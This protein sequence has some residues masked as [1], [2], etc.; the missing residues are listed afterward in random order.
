MKQ[1][2]TDRWVGRVVVPPG[3]VNVDVYDTVVPGLV[4]RVGRRTKSWA[5]RIVRNGQ[6]TRLSLGAFPDVPV[7]AARNAALE[8]QRRE[9]AE[10]QPTLGAVAVRFRDDYLPQLRP[11]TARDWK[12]IIDVE[13][14]PYLDE[15]HP[16][17]IAA[18]RTTIRARLNEIK[19]RSGYVA[20]R[21]HEVLR[22][23]LRWGVSES[24]LDPVTGAIFIAFERPM[25][26]ERVRTRI[27]T[28]AEIGA[29][30]AAI[31][32]EPLTA[33]TFW[34]MAFYTGQRRGEIL[35]A[36]WENIDLKKGVW[37]LEV[38]GGKEHWL[39]LPH[40]AIRLLRETRALQ[41]EKE[42]LCPAGSGAGHRLAV[43]KS[44]DRLR[45]ITEVMFRPH[46]VRRTV[47]TELAELGITDETV[48][49]VLAHSGG[50][51]RVTL[52][53][54]NLAKRVGETRGALQQW[55]NRLEEITRENTHDKTS[56][57][58]R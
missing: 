53:H 6:Y 32:T 12:R 2:L 15:V 18:A 58:D 1:E 42:W 16:T 46:D 10:P 25:R 52:R 38:K 28:H 54:Y 57:P 35:A 30:W 5:V 23:M 29:V 26:K 45:R 11:T 24:L 41:G 20:N 50:G 56:R 3:K 27:L 17:D 51:A 31:R 55:A 33:R 8:R 4:L 40:Q 48:S 13:I 49:R 19:A 9:R 37:K 7:G 14:L 22:R 44:A 47:G 39:G 43:Q 34:K 21:T 36:R